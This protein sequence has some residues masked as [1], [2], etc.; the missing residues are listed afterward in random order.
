[1]TK[2]DDKFKDLVHYVCF[3]CE[4]PS[5]MGA[6]KLNKVLWYSDVLA[7]LDFGKSITEETYLKRQF[8]PVPS[9]ILKALEALQD[10]GRVFIRDTTVFGFPSSQ[11][12]SLR[13]PDE[14]VFTERERGLIDSVVSQVCDGHTAR[15]V[16][17]LS[18][19]RAWDAADIGE[20]IPHF[21]AFM[22][23]YGELDEHDV[24]WA[25]DKIEQ[26]AA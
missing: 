21:A 22:S 19:N 16:S 15:S 1:M 14:S 4:N 6:T 17:L 11:Y 26:R 18:H 5:K 24:A 12:H 8:G 23:R 13:D 20:T 3:K 10:E 25:R 2:L 9:H 7:Y